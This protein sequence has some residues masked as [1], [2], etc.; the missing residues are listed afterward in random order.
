MPETA[1]HRLRAIVTIAKR[2]VVGVDVFP[3]AVTD[4][5]AE[6]IARQVVEDARAIAGGFR[7]SHPGQGPTVGIT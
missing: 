2:D 4:R 1:A 6:Q 7:L 3:A 5:D